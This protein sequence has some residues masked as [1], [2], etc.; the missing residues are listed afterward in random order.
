MSDNSARVSRRTLLKV[1]VAGGVALLLARWLYTQTSEPVAKDPQFAALDASARS[2]V[3]AIV[4]VMLEGALLEGEA[5][6]RARDQ[7]V[8]GVDR[9]VA[10]LP[11]AVRAEIDQLFSLL[12]FAPSRCLVAGV[13]SPWPEASRDSIVAFLG[14]W[15]DSRFGLLR[16]GF[17]ALHQLIVG[18]WYANPQAWPAI[19]YP[20]PPL[21]ESA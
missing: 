18:A 2:V 16:S 14:R 21:L 3:A 4:P 17:A 8:S 7:V 1:G 12:A 5:A 13:W 10:G 19:G 11:P 6:M 20:G 9:A 15:R